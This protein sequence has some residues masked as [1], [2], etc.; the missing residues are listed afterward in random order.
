[1]PDHLKLRTDPDESDTLALSQSIDPGNVDPSRVDPGKLFLYTTLLPKAG[2]PASA[3]RYFEKHA[4]Q[5]LATACYSAAK[6]YDYVVDTTWPPLHPL[7]VLDKDASIGDGMFPSLFSKV[8]SAHALLDGLLGSR[9]GSLLPGWVVFADADVAFLDVQFDLL[10]LIR[11]VQAARD[12]AE[13]DVPKEERRCHFIIQKT[14][15][16]PNTGFFFVFNSDYSRKI[17]LNWW[18][19]MHAH[20]WGGDRG[21]EQTTFTASM[22]REFGAAWLRKEARSQAPACIGCPSTT[23]PT[24]PRNHELHLL[25]EAAWHGKLCWEHDGYYN[26]VGCSMA[27]AAKLME[28]ESTNGMSLYA[29]GICV[30]AEQLEIFNPYE[31]VAPGKAA[32]GHT[33]LVAHAATAAWLKADPTTCPSGCSAGNGSI[34]VSVGDTLTVQWRNAISGATAAD[35]SSALAGVYGESCHKA[36]RS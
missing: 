36:R 35:V 12:A 6:G 26:F 4:S 22:L 14:D 9:A 15:H 20:G 33:P 7:Y 3:A 17:L 2:D 31:A 29:G 19:D 5:M 11:R 8:S 25:A 13:P 23:A 30:V 27:M 34:I 24:A 32:H 28:V 21:H 1:M 16:S 18:L 10:T